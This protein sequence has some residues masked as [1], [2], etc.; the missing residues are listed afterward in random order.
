MRLLRRARTGRRNLAELAGACSAE[1]F[2]MSMAGGAYDA[3]GTG[4]NR[5]FRPNQQSPWMAGRIPVLGTDAWDHGYYLKYQNVRTDY[6]AA[7]YKA[8]SWDFANPQ[9][10]TGLKR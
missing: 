5:K 10:H 3:R 4:P 1:R 2:V 8:I 6:V 7:F 9:H